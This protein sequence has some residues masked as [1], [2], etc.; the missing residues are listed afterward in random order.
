MVEYQGHVQVR[1]TFAGIATGNAAVE[2]NATEQRMASV[3]EGAAE[4]V[5]HRPVGGL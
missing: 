2:V 4:I 1:F 5:E 3:F